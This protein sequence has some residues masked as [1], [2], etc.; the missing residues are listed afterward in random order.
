MLDVRGWT[1]QA[2]QDC[3]KH[4]HGT[5]SDMFHAN[6]GWVGKEPKIALS[7]GAVIT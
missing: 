5:G 4:I 2:V 7:F 3:N 6:V 1:S